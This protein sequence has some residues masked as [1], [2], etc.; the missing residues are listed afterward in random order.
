MSLPCESRIWLEGG[1]CGLAAPR[2]TARPLEIDYWLAP[3]TSGEPPSINTVTV[4]SGWFTTLT[5][6]SSESCSSEECRLA[7]DPG[8]EEPCRSRSTLYCWMLEASWSI[9]VTVEAIWLS[10]L[11]DTWSSDADRLWTS[12]ARLP[13]L[14]ITICR[15]EVLSGDAAQ[16]EKLEYRLFRSAG[17]PRLPVTSNRFSMEETPVVCVSYLPKGCN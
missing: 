5:S 13:A 9:W 4:P 8:S 15:A 11:P 6:T 10:T 16:A 12:P 2:G 7:S 1:D 14:A 17:M 3:A